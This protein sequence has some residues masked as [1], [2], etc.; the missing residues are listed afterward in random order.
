MT[1]TQLNA[2]DVGVTLVKVSNLSNRR[3]DMWNG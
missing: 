3:N 2:F 1:S